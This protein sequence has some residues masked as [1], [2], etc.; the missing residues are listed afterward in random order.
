MCLTPY[1][2]IDKEGYE[3]IHSCRKCEDC[4]KARKRHWIGRLLAEE[5]TSLATWFGTFT[6]AG[7][8]DNDEAYELQYEHVQQ[9]FKR[10][11]KA[12]HKFKYLAVG[13]YGTAKGRAHWHI[14]FYFTTPPPTVEF[15]AM[16]QFPHWEKGHSQIEIPRSTQGSAAYMIDYITK[17]LSIAGRM[18]YSKNPAMG[19]TYLLEY[20]RE[21][22]RHGVALFP[23]GD[24]FTIP[25]NM[26]R[27]NKLFWYKVGN[28]TAIYNKMMDAFL[29]EWSIKRPDQRMALSADL[30]EYLS[31]VCQETELQPVSVQ[32]F[33]SEHY[34][35][36]P[37]IKTYAKTSIHHIEQ[38]WHIEINDYTVTVVITDTKGKTK[39]RGHV[40]LRENEE[41]NDH[42][43]TPLLLSKCIKK[44]HQSPLFPDIENRKTPLSKVTQFST[45]PLP[46]PRN[47]KNQNPRSSD[48]VA[49][50]ER[51]SM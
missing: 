3:M 6:Y 47:T 7:G 15:N 12:G 26:N 46:R 22:A 27:A 2:R 36:D 19:T 38:G 51:R 34:G 4:M 5:Q 14:L 16:I 13:E 28:Q 29:L 49:Q 18:R 50:T 23:D 24:V 33:I 25:D 43:V 35:Y 30:I 1:K 21:R 45:K 37:A 10:M 31:D 8:Y 44:L 42:N 39:W 40:E 11:R 48:A 9:M 41:I 17:D 20:A 32:R